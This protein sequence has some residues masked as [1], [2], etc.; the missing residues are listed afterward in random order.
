[1][2]GKIFKILESSLKFFPLGQ[3]FEDY[4][5]FGDKFFNFLGI[6][7]FD[8]NFWTM[9]YDHN[10]RLVFYIATLMISTPSGF[11]SG[12]GIYKDILE[13]QL[14]AFMGAFFAIMVS[15]SYYFLKISE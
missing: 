5:K 7:I 4:F 13:E 10:V 1:M 12:F 9:S 8:E 3:T 14:S 2:L 6:N 11:M 15:I